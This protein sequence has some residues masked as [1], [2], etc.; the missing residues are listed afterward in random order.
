MAFVIPNVPP[1]IPRTGNAVSAWTGR[2]TLRLLGWS[3]VGTIPAE[4]K[5]VLIVA[6]H[7][8]SWDFVVGLAAKLALRLDTSYL[9]KKSLFQWPL[10]VLLNHTGGIPVDRAAQHNLVERMAEHFSA[11]KSMVLTIAPEGTRRHVE[12]W[13]SGFYRIAEAAGV[14]ILPV[15]F[16]Y[17]KKAI[18]FGEPLL[19]S[20]DAVGE[21]KQLRAFYKNVEPRIAH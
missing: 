2:A 5:F 21:T 20:G 9:A 18:A 10:S 14:P 13:K 16:D 19:P 17:A 15:A 4:P 12:Q 6:P 11:R 1:Q 7:T 3:I 8:S